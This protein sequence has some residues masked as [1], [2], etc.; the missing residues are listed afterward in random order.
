MSSLSFLEF[1]D[2]VRLARA[3]ERFAAE[4]VNDLAGVLGDRLETGQI[5]DFPADAPAADEPMTPEALTAR[6]NAVIGAN[7]P[8]AETSLYLLQYASGTL[9]CEVCLSPL[10]H[11]RLAESGTP[12]PGIGRLQD[13]AF[14]ELL[15][16]RIGYGE[17]DR[18][19]LYGISFFNVAYAFFEGFLRHPL[20]VDVLKHRPGVDRPAIQ[21][22][23]DYL[24][25][26]LSVQGSDVFYDTGIA[27]MARRDPA[28]PVPWLDDHIERL[29]LRRD[30][31]LVCERFHTEMLSGPERSRYLAALTALGVSEAA[32]LA[33]ADLPTRRS[34]GIFARL[35]RG[36]EGT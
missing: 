21:A 20:G 8:A 11:A 3:P 32:A 23:I 13:P 15:L 35:W 16:Y 19:Q 29:G 2:I 25:E 30:S 22:A 6:L 4:V 5:D 9:S 31:G 27:A 17:I 18:W 26:K 24:F 12:P 1:F 7:P 10:I 33:A 34:A 36:R 28:A 14:A